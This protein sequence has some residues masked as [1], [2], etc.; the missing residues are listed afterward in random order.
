[1]SQGR[2]TGDL[3]VL[4]VAATICGAILLGVIGV[5]VV[6]IARPKTD[7]TGLV[8]NLGDVIN[9]MVGLMAGFLAGKTGSLRKRREDARED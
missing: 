2:S 3:L 1:M 5:F 7:L 6:S 9:T 8:G 4:I